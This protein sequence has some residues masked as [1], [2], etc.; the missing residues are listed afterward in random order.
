[1]QLLTLNRFFIQSLERACSNQLT[2]AALPIRY[3]RCQKYVR[4]I[5]K[6]KTVMHLLCLIKSNYLTICKALLILHQVV[7]VT[8][9]PALLE[10]TPVNMMKTIMMF[11]FIHFQS[12]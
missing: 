6:S 9:S 7:C 4:I 1:M 11:M 5:F 12:L 2:E 8:S 10:N 3:S